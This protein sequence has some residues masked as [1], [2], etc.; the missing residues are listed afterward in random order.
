[1]ERRI[2]FE[3]KL[4]RTLLDGKLLATMGS[5]IDFRRKLAH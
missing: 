4:V 5:K 3:G 2:S 1:M